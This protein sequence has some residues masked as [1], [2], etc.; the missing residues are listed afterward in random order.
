MVP[1]FAEHV[2]ALIAAVV[3]SDLNRGG[4]ALLTTLKRRHKELNFAT[5]V[6]ELLSERLC[7]P[8][9]EDAC[10]ACNT[11]RVHPDFALRVLPL[12]QNLLVFD[13]ILTT[14]MTLAATKQL[15]EPHHKNMLFVV[16]INN[17]T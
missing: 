14:G 6:C 12:E 7:V 10:V 11:D 9:Y 15:F 8:F 1:Y 16:G 5:R 2:S 13:D 3:G 4:W 17:R